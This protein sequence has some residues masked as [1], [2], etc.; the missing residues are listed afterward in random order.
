MYIQALDEQRVGARLQKL[1]HI[2]LRLHAGHRTPA[3]YGAKH[4]RTVA[5]SKPPNFSAC[6]PLAGDLTDGVTCNT[7]DLNGILTLDN[8]LW[9]RI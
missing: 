9:Q 5:G 2:A 6:V 7:V 8:H 3:V 4:Q 1:H